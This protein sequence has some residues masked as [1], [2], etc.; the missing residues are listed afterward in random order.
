MLKLGKIQDVPTFMK[1]IGRNCED[2]AGKFE[3]VTILFFLIDLVEG[4]DGF[5]FSLGINYL[6]LVVVL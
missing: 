3:V 6:L 1:A 5:H 4:T 2:L